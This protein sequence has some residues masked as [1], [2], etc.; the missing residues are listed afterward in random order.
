MDNNALFF[1]PIFVWVLGFITFALVFIYHT[2]P[3]GLSDFW[4]HL[5][6]ARWI[7]SAGGLPTNDP[8]LYSSPSPLDARASLILRG[9]PL[10]QLLMLGI[11]SMGG[12]Y[13]LMVLKGLL[14][15][16]FYGLLWNHFRRNGLHPLLALAVAGSLPLLFFRF[17]ELRPQ[18]FSFIGT[19]LVI[20]QTEY[21][22]ACGK[23]GKKLKWYILPSLPLLML[24]WANF[25]RG[26]IIGIGILLV[27]LLTEWIARK[28]GN[29]ALP[30]DAFRH[31]LIVV[32]ASAGIAF[33]NPVGITAMWASFTEVSGPFAQVID[34]FFGTIGYFELH[35]MKQLGYLVV[36]VAAIPF[37]ALLVKWRKVSTAHL[38]IATLFLIA[39]IQSF[40]FSL[41]MV[42][43]VLSIA[44]VYFSDA[45]N[46]G[47]SVG[48]GIP[49]ILLWCLSTGFLANSAFSR[50]AL[51]APPL[52]KGVIPTAAVDY[53]EQSNINGN[54]YNFFEYGGYLS[55]RLYPRKVF[56]D[57]RNLSWDVYEEY[58]K[59]WRG[60]YAEV[61]DK[62]RIGAVF[63]PVYEHATGKP[64]RLVAGLFNDKQWGVGYFDG[65]DVVFVR[66]DNNSHLTLLDKRSIVGEIIQR[67]RSAK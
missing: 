13:A 15:T 22:I 16:L 37:I 6:N 57:Q 49:I 24:L 64:S 35:G 60:N 46:R 12:I 25:H 66:I 28:R 18:I 3:L 17:D 29:T 67:I 27:Y 36:A 43:V 51:T 7:W 58:S 63:Y 40:R 42:A 65:K 4:W 33:F 23:Q 5:N 39:G 32:L 1:K 10:S 53:L 61:F 20:Q 54:I 47:L 30:D 8:F 31:F 52:E 38:L 59:A 44:I 19:L 62:Y 11:Y 41:M 26:F 55:W 45:F 14:M 2:F 50:T 56:I 48:K 34:E 9:Y 21:I